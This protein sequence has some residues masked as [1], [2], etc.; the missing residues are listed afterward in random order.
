MK[1]RVGPKLQAEVN[2]ASPHRCR[3]A[4]DKVRDILRKPEYAELLADM[5]DW[6]GTVS[7]T[8]WIKP[9]RVS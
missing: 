4:A 5:V 6:H 2:T 3:A 7:M 9:K 1:D 8:V